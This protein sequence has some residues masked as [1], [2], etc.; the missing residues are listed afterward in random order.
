MPV[1]SLCIEEGG[2]LR[3]KIMGGTWVSDA[4]NVG[5]GGRCC[6]QDLATV[7]PLRLLAKQEQ[8]RA[9]M[10]FGCMLRGHA[11]AQDWEKKK[12]R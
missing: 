8:G 11:N 10:V 1:V 7:W 2:R 5:A 12:K 6:H 4:C 3:V 9:K